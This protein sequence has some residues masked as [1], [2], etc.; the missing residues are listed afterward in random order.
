MTAI[1]AAV[2][3]ACVTSGIAIHLRR[4]WRRNGYIELVVGRYVVSVD[5]TRRAGGAS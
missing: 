2:L 5:Q 1:A 4:L 3:I